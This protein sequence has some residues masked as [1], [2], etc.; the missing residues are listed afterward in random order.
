MES[1]IILKHKDLKLLIEEVRES[2]EIQERELKES[3][4]EFA[5]AL[6]PVQVAK[7]T[8]HTLVKDKEVQFDLVKG[9]MT[10]GA[11][12][13]IESI[14]NRNNTIKGFLSS[15][16]LERVSTTLISAN[17]PQIIIGITDIITGKLRKA[18]DSEEIEE[19]TDE[20]NLD[21]F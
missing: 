1:P 20:T 4:K 18:E 2:K 5:H 17:A 9:G 21:S 6:S 13:I 14:F 12:F 11:N 10:L 3:F 7:S 15:A 8:L 16:I 19:A